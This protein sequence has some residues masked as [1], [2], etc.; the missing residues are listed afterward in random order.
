MPDLS[1]VA[2]ARATAIERLVDDYLVSCR[3]RGLSPATV[4]RGYAHPLHRVLLP[5]CRNAGIESVE[6]LDQRALDRLT[7]TLLTAERAHGRPLSRAS[8]ASYT[9][10]VRLFLAWCEREGEAV[11]AKPQMPR[12]PKRVREVLTRDEVEA[13]ETAAPAERDQLII[14]LLADTGLRV[15]ELCR[16]RP[17]D[18]VRQ[19]RRVYLRVE[20]KGLRERLVPLPPALA[21]RIERHLRGRPAD[22]SSERL[23]LSLRR[24]PHGDFDALTPSGILQLIHSAAQRAGV[25]KR[26]HPHAL[27][28]AWMT[29][30]LRQGM[31]PTSSPASPA[32][33]SRSSRSTTS[34]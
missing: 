30:M 31:N 6:L 11:V 28:H 2:P 25:R 5:W 1:V 27:R 34:T 13:L 19:D 21:R 10:V 20:G 32:P 8:V 12:V 15:G 33:R 9:R 23:F 14:R 7:S 3:A 18:V 16:L 22:T 17:E 26:I 24:S 29:E 4:E